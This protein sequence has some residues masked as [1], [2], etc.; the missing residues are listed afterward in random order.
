MQI[1][2]IGAGNMG[3]V[4]GGNLA[5]TGQAVTFVDIWQEQIDAIRNNGLQL[6]GLHGDFTVQVGATSDPAQAPKADIALIC[7]NTYATA[8]AAQTAK[9][10]LKVSGYAVTLQNGLGN[11]EIL[12]EVLGPER[13]LG[14][15][16]FHSGDLQAP[17]KVMH[18]NS[19]P[20]Y[21]GELDK[22][23][24]ARLQALYTLMDQAGMHPQLEADIMATI[25]GK[26]VH[27]CGIN[28]ICA[29]TGL[30][31]G[32][33]QEVPE[34][35]EFQSRIIAEVLALVQAKGIVL[36]DPSP[37]ESIKAYS[38]KKFHRVSMLQHLERGSRTEIDSLNGYVVRE[39]AKLGLSAPYNDA[40]TRLMQ[41][42]HHRPV[43]TDAT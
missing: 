38:A 27:N 37:L 4:Y 6:S 33:I 14:G 30:R 1:A 21:L 26:F 22:S 12:S 40:L 13:L 29:I 42:R 43:H 19:G 2:V 16:T 25:W 9:S 3:C 28:A 36:P 39:S 31:P 35:D 7:V 18:T 20:T 23:Q 8:P 24:T 10:L 34:L 32:N 15:L 5:R 41:G 17:G 11:I